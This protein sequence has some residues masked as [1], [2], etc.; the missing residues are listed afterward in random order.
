MLKKL[1]KMLRL[2]ACKRHR[3]LNLITITIILLTEIEII[4]KAI[5]SV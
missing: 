1:T 5:V 2:E 4:H 3:I